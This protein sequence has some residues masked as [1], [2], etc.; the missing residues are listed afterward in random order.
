MLR[1][2]IGEDVELV[3]LL[4]P[5]MATVRADPGQIEQIVINLVVNARDAMPGGGRVTIETGVAE[6]GEDYTQ[7]HLDVKPG[8]YV[9]ISVTD[10]GQ[11]MAQTTQTHIF[12]PFFTTKSMGK[13]TG[14]GLSTIYGIVKQNNGNI[15]VYSEPGKGSTFKIYLPAVDEQPQVSP[16]GAAA[17]LQK[18]SETILLVEDESGLREMVQELLERQGYT[19]LPAASSHEAIRICGSY[20]GPVHLLLTDVVLPTSSGHELARRLLHFRRH[21][22]V[23]FMSGYPAET[24]MQRG[25]LEPGAAFLEKPFTPEVLARK[26]REALGGAMGATQES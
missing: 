24:I 17:V 19:V 15:W 9:C 13:G 3:L 8:R 14:L 20:P 6:L 22:R 1:R 2:L 10:T 4:N 23:L 18:G 25:V 12:E 26:V 7:K 16:A 11:G 5:T 21:I